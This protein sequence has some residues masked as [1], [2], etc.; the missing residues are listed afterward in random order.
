MITSVLTT[1]L[2][3]LDN[4]RITEEERD[5][6]KP[7]TQNGTTIDSQP[8]LIPTVNGGPAGVGGFFQTSTHSPRLKISDVVSSKTGNKTGKENDED[9]VSQD[10][11]SEPMENSMKTIDEVN[12]EESD[13]KSASDADL[14][15]SSLRFCVAESNSIRE[16]LGLKPIDFENLRLGDDD[17]DEEDDATIEDID[18]GAIDI[19][20]DDD[21][22]LDILNSYADVLDGNEDDDAEES[23]VDEFYD[24]DD[25]EEED[26]VDVSNETD[27]DPSISESTRSSS[28]KSSL[29]SATLLLLQNLSV[30]ELR[31]VERAS[32]QLR[33]DK[34]KTLKDFAWFLERLKFVVALRD[35]MESNERSARWIRKACDWK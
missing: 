25:G 32:A 18:S 20:E 27:N 12:P 23:I 16:K 8:A 3:F 15:E 31:E 11:F 7:V 28:N 35:P 17:D 29:L 6:A 14:L 21:E 22:D 26:E 9:G 4:I 30:D 19:D 24:D 2:N 13:K 1:Q 34:T 5:L 33:L 10:E